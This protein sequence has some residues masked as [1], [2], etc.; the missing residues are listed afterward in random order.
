MAGKTEIP[1]FVCEPADPYVKVIENE[2][3]AGLNPMELASFVKAELDSGKSRAAIA[4]NLGKS[5]ASELRQRLDRRRRLAE[6]VYRSGQCRGLR[7]LCELCRAYEERPEDVRRLIESGELITRAGIRQML[8]GLTKLASNVGA[9][10]PSSSKDPDQVRATR[11]TRPAG[12]SRSDEAKESPIR[13][14]RVL[15]HL[16]LLA[17]TSDG[18]AEVLF[19]ALPESKD[20]VFVIC[21]ISKTRRLVK[22]AE[23]HDLRLLRS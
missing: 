3:R 10:M 17:R 5:A 7:E 16:S 2:H 6:D 23:L 1:A 13:R 18:L 15:S 12:N 8:D 22:L 19:G 20:E 11:G 4:R 14:Q 9:Q 21:P